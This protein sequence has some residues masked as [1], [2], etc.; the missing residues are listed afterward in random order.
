M[1]HGLTIVL[2]LAACNPNPPVG[3]PD[4]STEP[5]DDLSMSFADLSMVTA[6]DLAKADLVMQSVPDLKSADLL[7]TTSDGGPKVEPG[8]CYTN[9]HCGAMRFC[10]K[11]VPGGV[12]DGCM[13]FGANCKAGFD[14]ECANGR[15]LR[16][17]TDDN[18]CLPGWRCASFMGSKY[19][20]LKSCTV[21]A[22]C[23]PHLDCR[24]NGIGL[25]CYRFLCP[26]STCPNGTTCLNGVCVENY[27]TF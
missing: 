22:D 13:G 23:G 5:A 6:N 9:A 18:G 10:D 8:Q 1:R 2:L 14:D 17:C 3:D 19:C 27:L 11:E 24:N 15:C 21:P 25:L 16:E 26:A 12:C 7:A 4:M 20:Q